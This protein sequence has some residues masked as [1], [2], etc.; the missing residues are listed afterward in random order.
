MPVRLLVSGEHACFPRP[1]CR[2]DRVTYD[3][4]TPAAARGVLDAI[5]WR[6]GM[7]WIVDAIQVLHPVE[8]LWR[9]DPPATGARTLILRDVAYLVEAHFELSAVEAERNGSG[10]HAAMF[11]RRAR[12]GQSRFPLY[13]GDRDFS[14]HVQLLS[15]DDPLP[16]RRFPAGDIDFGWLLHDVVREGGREPQFFRAIARDGLI[17]V[18]REGDPELVR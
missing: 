12:A 5:H 18:P 2:I 13:L 14:A 7:R 6:P 9:P 1:E 10:Q 15:K 16:P 8:R 4:M 11:K 3:V 17:R